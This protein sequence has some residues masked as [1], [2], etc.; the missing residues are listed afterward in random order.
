MDGPV[1]IMGL[2]AIGLAIVAWMLLGRGT[3]LAEKR[4]LS[5]KKVGIC[6]Y[7]IEVEFQSGSRVWCQ[8]YRGNYGWKL[9]PQGDDLDVLDPL[10]D[11]LDTYVQQY[12]WSKEH[13]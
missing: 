3:L 7:H 11:W 9:Y 2:S 1:L 5:I 8:Q 13:Q 4:V 6:D 12:E 10:D